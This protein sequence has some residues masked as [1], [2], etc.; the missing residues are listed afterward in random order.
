V[1]VPGLSLPELPDAA[2]LTL[3]LEGVTLGGYGWW[4]PRPAPAALLLHGWGQ[5]ASA[6][7][8]PAR[9][10]YARGWHAVSLSLRGW[11]GSSGCDDYG[12]SGPD[13]TL[14]ALDWLGRQPFVTSTALLGLSLGGLIGL[15]VAARENGARAVV[16]VNPPTDLHRVY[17]TTSSRVLREYYDAVLTGAQWE[18]GSPIHAAR[19]LQTPA[20][21][22]VGTQDRICSPSLGHGYAQASGA[23][24]LEVAGMGHVPDEGEWAF[25]M[26]R[27]LSFQT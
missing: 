1:E 9:L 24:L 2:R 20:W 21:V 5:D 8:A 16:A 18:A 11:R 27:A 4:Q 19:Q 12:L 10:L 3:P 23:R 13:D 7:A 17:Q 25:I 22:V 15:L 26:Q 14:R 6:L